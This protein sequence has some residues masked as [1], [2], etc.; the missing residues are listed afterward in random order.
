MLSYNE[1]GT[2][3]F[4]YRT[5]GVHGMGISA[6]SNFAVLY[7]A[8]QE[9]LKHGPPFCRE[10]IAATALQFERRQAQGLALAAD[11][12][13]PIAFGGV[14]KVGTAPNTLV[15]NQEIA[16]KV[17][18]EQIPHDPRWLAD[19]VV[20][21][22][23][24]VGTRHDVPRLLDK[25]IRHPNAPR[26]IEQFSELAESAST[27]IVKSDIHQLAEN[28]NAYRAGFD[29]WTIDA[30]G[31]PIF[32]EPVKAIADELMDQLPLKVLGWKPPGG[33]ASE[34]MIVLSPNVRSRDAVIKF[35]ATKNWL[36]MPALVTQG[37]CGEFMNGAGG[38]IRITAGHRLDLVGGADLGQDIAIGK[39]GWCCSCAIEP[40]S[41]ITLST[42][43]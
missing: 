29:A 36:A 8:S 20:V 42:R 4:C 12:V 28:V 24:K 14:L 26:Y 6:S 13:F 7:S 32:T 35:F 19:H 39:A 22:F 41:E 31:R 11:D 1:L 17:T 27:A 9:Y 40:R 30:F 18:V 15:D 3:S 5:R 34:S 38:D 23:N 16:G 2:F 21:A 43:D 25:L 37:V 10:E 33:G